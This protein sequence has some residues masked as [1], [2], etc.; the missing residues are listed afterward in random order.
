LFNFVLA[1]SKRVISADSFA[2]QKKL[3]RIFHKLEKY[4]L[5]VIAEAFLFAYQPSIIL[6]ER[7]A[8]F[9]ARRHRHNI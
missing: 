6:L 8:L 3:W 9:S 7:S 2:I 1:S 4:K 5:N